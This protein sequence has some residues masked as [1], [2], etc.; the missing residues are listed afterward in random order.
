MRI[1]KTMFL[2][3]ALLFGTGA[4]L[5]P[6]AQASLWNQ[7]IKFTFNQPVAIPGAVLPAGTYWFRLL[8]STSDR[9]IVQIYSENWSQLYAT[10]Q[11]NAVL[12]RASTGKI[13]LQFAKRPHDR[14]QALLEWYYP[15]MRY[16]HE[17]IYPASREALFSRSAKLEL[18]SSP[19]GSRKVVVAEPAVG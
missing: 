1:S 18:L 12:R 6:K 11:T 4:A 10:E 16:G 9:N 13:E 8:N 5:A 19:Y 3:L 7:A 17:F 14:P 2:A 15:G